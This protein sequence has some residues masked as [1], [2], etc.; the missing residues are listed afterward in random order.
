MQSN[1]NNSSMGGQ[2]FPLFSNSKILSMSDQELQNN[3]NEF[4]SYIRRERRAGRDTKD[5]EIEC[6][7]LLQEKDERN[8]Y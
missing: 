3:I 1:V 2:N 4:Q 5:A 6:A 8:R 7:Y